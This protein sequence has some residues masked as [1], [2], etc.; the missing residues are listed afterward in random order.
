MENFLQE[1]KLN[2]E[3]NDDMQQLSDNKKENILT[4]Q[5]KQL[6]EE[7]VPKNKRI[8]KTR[9][10]QKLLKGS[11]VELAEENLSNEANK[12][13]KMMRKLGINMSKKS[14]NATKKVQKT[15][16]KSSLEPATKTN[17]TKRK[18]K[19]EISEFLDFCPKFCILNDFFFVF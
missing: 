4:L 14:T 3:N 15:E 8:K 11:T 17:R 16:Q 5:N 12:K 9:K 6:A 1:I 18:N 13:K 19:E 7:N 10:I 2:C